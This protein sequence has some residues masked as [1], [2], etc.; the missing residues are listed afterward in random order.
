MSLISGKKISMATKKKQFI[1]FKLYLNSHSF[2]ERFKKKILYIRGHAMKIIF[3]IIFIY[4][5]LS[6]LVILEMR[7]LFS[8][9][10]KRHFVLKL[11][12]S[13]L[14]CPS[15]R[16]YFIWQYQRVGLFEDALTKN[17]ENNHSLSSEA[18]KRASKFCKLCK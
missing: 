4:C 15:I 17:T 5:Y 9:L 3:S 10:V 13:V 11:N 7:L 14:Q 12:A 8:F 2:G 18:S 16:F 6:F 1:L